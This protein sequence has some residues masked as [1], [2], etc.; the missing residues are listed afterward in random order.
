MFLLIRLSLFVFAFS[1]LFALNSC[2]QT[3]R[4]RE[5]NSLSDSL[6]TKEYL[7]DLPYFPFRTTDDQGVFTITVDVENDLIAKK[8]QKVF[9]QYEYSGNGYT[10]EG[11]ITQ[12]LMIEDQELLEN[13]T[14]DSEAGAFYA[15]A[16]NKA[17]Q[18][19][20]IRLM[21]PIFEQTD[22]LEFYL[23]QIPHDL[24]VD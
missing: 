17:N 11:I 24:I 12:I 3:K 20:F 4:N 23:N 2:D 6:E 14:L 18:M 5:I 16:E 1:S 9:E 22:K 8:Y 13:L 7:T 15:E 19:R 10:W 21:R